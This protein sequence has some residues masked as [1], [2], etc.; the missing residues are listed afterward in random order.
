MKGKNISI[1]ELITIKLLVNCV[2]SQIP[3]STGILFEQQTKAEPNDTNISQKS[4]F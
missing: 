4:V 2:L 1:P 3:L